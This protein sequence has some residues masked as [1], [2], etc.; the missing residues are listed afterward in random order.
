MMLINQTE[1]RFAD[2]DLRYVFGRT[3]GTVESRIRIQEILPVP[4][5]YTVESR[6][7]SQLLIGSENC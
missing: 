7:R 5:Y 3:P 4:R 1:I 2:L 6:I